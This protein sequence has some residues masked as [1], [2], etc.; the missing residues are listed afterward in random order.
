MSPELKELKEQRS[1]VLAQLE[2]IDRAIASADAGGALGETVEWLRSQLGLGS[3]E[4][5]TLRLA[6]EAAGHAW[7]TVERA[8]VALAVVT[9]K[10]S[11]QSGWRWLLPELAD[12]AKPDASKTA[13]SPSKAATKTA[14]Q[15]KQAELPGMPPKPPRAPSV[16]EENHAEFQTSRRKRLERLG[17]EYVPDEQN[18]PAFVVVSMKR[19]RDHCCDDDELFALFDLFLN[20]P[21]AARC[22]PPFPLRALAAEKTWRRLLG[23]LRGAMHAEAH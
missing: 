19:L 13:K 2:A 6:A 16:H 23:Q 12:S 9:E 5:G 3:R 7:R 15:K 4:V 8:K 11:F 20:E 14:K 21:W 1:R 18:T 17:V 22:S 10:S